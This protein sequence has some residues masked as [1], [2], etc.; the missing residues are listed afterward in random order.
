VRPPPAFLGHAAALWIAQQVMDLRATAAHTL[1]SKN[2]SR[3]G[4]KVLL[5]LEPK[6]L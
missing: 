3:M 2:D 1:E 6:T 4:P 5:L